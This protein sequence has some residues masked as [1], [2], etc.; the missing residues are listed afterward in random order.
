MALALCLTPK[1]PKPE[2]KIIQSG[3]KHCLWGIL[4]ESND[5]LYGPFLLSLF[6]SLIIVLFVVSISFSHFVVLWSLIFVFF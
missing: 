2:T 3:K 6:F 4:S 5:H 1:I